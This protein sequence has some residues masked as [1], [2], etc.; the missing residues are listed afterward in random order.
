MK[1]LLVLITV[2]LMTLSLAACGS[3][4]YQVTTRSGQTFTANGSPDYDVQSETYKFKDEEGKEVILS[5]E[6]IEVIK[7]K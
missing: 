4:T 7:E 1:R 3:K 6:E 5:K 2:L